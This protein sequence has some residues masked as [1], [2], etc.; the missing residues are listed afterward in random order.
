M[1]WKMTNLYHALITMFSL[2]C[3]DWVNFRNVSSAL[4]KR[5]LPQPA[6]CVR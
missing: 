3:G 6:L 2:I 1:L 4:Y 5:I